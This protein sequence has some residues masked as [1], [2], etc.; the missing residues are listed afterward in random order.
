MKTPDSKKDKD[1][2][3]AAKAGKIRLTPGFAK[4]EVIKKTGAGIT[5][6]V[7]CINGDPNRSAT[8]TIRGEL[9]YYNSR[10]TVSADAEIAV[11]LPD[12]INIDVNYIF[13][14]AT[15]QPDPLRLGGGIVKGSLAEG[16]QRIMGSTDPLQ[17]PFVKTE[18]VNGTAWGVA[19]FLTVPAGTSYYEGD[20]I[21]GLAIVDPVTRDLAVTPFTLREGDC[22][23][24]IA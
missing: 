22:L 1:G 19:V 9:K 17:A 7:P 5:I 11:Y 20:V 15:N 12:G 6:S 10:E 21:F 13:P 23:D 8:S 3:K 4:A 24:T 18:W 16:A 2:K 14:W